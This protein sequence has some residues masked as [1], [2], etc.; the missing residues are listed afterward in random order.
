MLF[1]IIGSFFSLSRIVLLVVVVVFLSLVFM[2]TST[3]QIVEHFCCFF[4]VKVFFEAED[5]KTKQEC[6]ISFSYYRLFFCAFKNYLSYCCYCC[7]L[8]Y[9]ILF[10]SFS[11]QLKICVALLLQRKFSLKIFCFFWRF[12]F[13]K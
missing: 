6:A 1:L 2:I 9:N 11:K 13:S 7:C 4:V 3:F 10:C 5:H 12:S 8:F